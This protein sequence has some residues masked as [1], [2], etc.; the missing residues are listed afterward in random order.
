MAAKETKTKK[1]LHRVGTEIKE[2]PPRV[3]ATTKRK[4]GAARAEA[5]RKAI[6]L[7]KAR[8][9]GAKIPKAPTRKDVL[10]RIKER[11]ATG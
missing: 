1:I 6:L 2:R 4:F 11:S 5:Q 3:L 7:S 9:A 10:S 8:E